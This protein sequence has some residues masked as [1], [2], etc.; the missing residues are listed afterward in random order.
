MMTQ[1]PQRLSTRCGYAVPAL[2]SAAGVLPAYTAAMENAAAAY[3]Q[4]ANYNPEAASY[5]VPNGYNRRVLL[6]LN[7]RSLVH[8]IR[9]RSAA[10]AH[11]SVRRAAQRMA[12]EVCAQFPELTSL[13]GRNENE[14]SQTIESAYF[15]NTNLR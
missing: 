7:L 10:N 9:L 11:F 5:V 3:E 14:T 6:H 15:S 4:L 1:T 12:E 13:L 8:F 2:I